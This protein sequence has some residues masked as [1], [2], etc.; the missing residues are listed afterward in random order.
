VDYKDLFKKVENAIAVYTSEL[1]LSS[2]GD[3]EVRG[4]QRWT[5]KEILLLISG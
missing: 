1:E 3:P 4:R 2:G 5:Y